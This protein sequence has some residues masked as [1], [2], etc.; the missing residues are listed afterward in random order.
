MI[1]MILFFATYIKGIHT[2]E[3]ITINLQ[4]Y[5]T[6]YRVGQNGR[7]PPG[8]LFKINVVFSLLVI[9]YS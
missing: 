8:N 3:Y 2:V 6:I 1:I 7:S 9:G 4:K 5:I